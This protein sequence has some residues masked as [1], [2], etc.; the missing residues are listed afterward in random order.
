MQYYVV[1]RQGEV[2]TEILASMSDVT[3]ER[4]RALGE[5]AAERLCEATRSC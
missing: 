2:F 4:A 5:V 1:V 3:E